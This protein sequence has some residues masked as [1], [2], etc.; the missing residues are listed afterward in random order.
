M[1]GL[2]RSS[3]GKVM[4]FGVFRGGR[5]G[6]GGAMVLIKCVGMRKGNGRLKE[7]MRG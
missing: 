4:V 6:F 1:R 3:D 2:S 5:I 7:V